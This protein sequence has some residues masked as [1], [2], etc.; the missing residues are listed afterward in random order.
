MKQPLTLTNFTKKYGAS[1][2]AHDISLQVK[3]GEV[4]GFLGPNG[5]G[6]T[7]TI[8]A[9]LNFIKP[10]SGSISLFGKDS[11]TDSV[12]V[13]HD[14]GYLAGDIALYGHMNGKELLEYIASLG[15]KVDWKY[16][17]QL[18][19]QLKAQLD[20]PIKDLSKGNKQ[21][22]GLMQAFMHKPA[23]ILLDEP[24][25]GLDPLMQQVFYDIVEEAQREGRSIFISSHNLQEVQRLCTRAA[26]IREGKLI[27]IEEIGE[28]HRLNYRRYMITF[29]KQPNQD[30]LESIESVSD[31]SVHKNQ[32][33]VTVTGQPN[34]FLRALSKYDV[35]DLGEEEVH[36]ED[37]FMHYYEGDSNE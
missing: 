6:K 36:L 26:F 23:L 33:R 20:R 9:I 35:L 16:V 27:A 11:V 34:K 3:P 32:A 18:A 5:A 25:S 30:E 4:F 8:R 12:A 10:T 15:K 28:S 7:T 21:K 2:G 24:T 19:D 31:V 17:D 14:I 1:I 13:K 22:I 29:K 37:M